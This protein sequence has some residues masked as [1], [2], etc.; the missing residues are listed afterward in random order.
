[1]STSAAI[2]AIRAAISC[3]LVAHEMF[4]ARSAM[5]AFAKNLYQVYKICFFHRRKGR[6]V[7]LGII[8]VV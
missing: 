8:F 6:K 2:A 1:M 4:A 5:A 7:F 3:K